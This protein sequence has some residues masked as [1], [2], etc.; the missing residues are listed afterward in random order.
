MTEVG[1]FRFYI[2]EKWGQCVEN[3]PWAI[4]KGGMTYCKMMRSKGDK[5]NFTNVYSYWKWC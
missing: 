2:W 3:L 5:I 1:Y 4:S